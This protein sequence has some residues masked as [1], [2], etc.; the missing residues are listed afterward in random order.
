MINVAGKPFEETD[1]IL[2][3]E[4]FVAG[5]DIV[6]EPELIDHPEVFTHIRGELLG[7]FH[8]TRNWYYWVARGKV[9]IEVAD[10]IYKHPYGKQDVRSGGHCGRP[11]PR[12]YGVDHV[13]A[14]GKKLTIL[15]DD[16]RDLLKKCEEDEAWAKVHTQL[17]LLHFVE[18]EEELKTATVYSYVD[19][20]HIDSQAGLKVYCDAIRNA[21]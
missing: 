15:T 10:E 1:E 20:Y 5:I 13:D 2:K 18:T 9:P 19:C 16:A 3:A 4:L 6:E 11:D 7:R 8:F 14:E 12:E 21:L 17:K